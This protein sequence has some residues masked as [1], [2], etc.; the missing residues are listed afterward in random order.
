MNPPITLDTIDR[1]CPLPEKSRLA[2]MRENMAIVLKR[3]QAVNEMCEKIRECG[4]NDAELN[5][6]MDVRYITESLNYDAGDATIES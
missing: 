4:R 2:Q 5:R 6:G 1:L 3:E